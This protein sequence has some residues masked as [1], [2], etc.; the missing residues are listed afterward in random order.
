M[1]KS[2]ALRSK[3][4]K[5]NLFHQ[6]ARSSLYSTLEHGRCHSHRSAADCAGCIRPSVSWDRRFSWCQNELII[7]AQGQRPTSA[8]RRQCLTYLKYSTSSGTRR[9]EIAVSSPPQTQKCIKCDCSSADTMFVAACGRSRIRARTESSPCNLQYYS[10]FE[11]N[12]ASSRQ[13]M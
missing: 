1:P 10:S 6:A 12:T 5:L 8:S 7:M 3:V 13:S 9:R 4:V 11:R 2:R